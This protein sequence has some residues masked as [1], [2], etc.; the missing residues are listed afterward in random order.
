MEYQNINNLSMD[1]VQKDYFKYGIHDL[2]LNNSLKS[3][4]NLYSKYVLENDFSLDL[5]WKLANTGNRKR[6]KIFAQ[7]NTLIY[8][9]LKKENPNA[10]KTD[11]S[12]ETRIYEWLINEFKE[13]TSYTQEHLEILSESL[14]MTFGDNW[15]F[16]SKK[17]GEILHQIYNIDSKKIK[18]CPP[19]EPLFY[20][21]IIPIGGQGKRINAYIIKSRIEV[22][23]I[24]KEL[25][26]TSSDL[27]LEYSI[28]K[29]KTK[30]LN[31]LDS[32][33]KEIL[34]EGVF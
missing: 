18:I 9:E 8:H 14:I 4:I 31:Q 6:G 30:I 2:I 26:A 7:T 23:D 21:N 29:R 24:K 5:A 34:L 33:S 27:S 20:K 16:S 12:I 11:Y 1:Q 25:D 22:S 13:G 19:I 32:N 15:S 17:I 28:Q 10:F 3:M